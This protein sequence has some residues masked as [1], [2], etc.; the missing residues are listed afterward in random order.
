MVL[1]YALNICIHKVK[2][3]SQEN[4]TLFSHLSQEDQK[5]LFAFAEVDIKVNSVTKT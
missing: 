4:K 3:K 2:K 5:P 1:W